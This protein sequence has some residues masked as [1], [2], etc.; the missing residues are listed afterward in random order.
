MQNLA[1]LL[2]LACV[3]GRLFVGEMPMLSP[4]LSMG[5]MS[6]AIQPTINLNEPMRVSFAIVLL[7]ATAGWLL[8]GAMTGELRTRRRG[9]A[10]LMGVFV[11]LSLV[12]SLQAA[13]KR[14]AMVIWVEQFSLMAACWLAAQVFADRRHMGLLLAFAAGAGAVLCLKGF[15]QVFDEIPAMQAAREELFGRPLTV[16]D[17]LHAARAAAAKPAGFFPL[18]NAFGSVLILL[19]AALAAVTVS[20]LHAGAAAMRDVSAVR[21]QIPLPLLQ[22]VCA[23]AV[24]VGCG[25]VLMMTG[26]AGAVIAAAVAAVCAGLLAV[27]AS[28]L[29]RHWRKTVVIS[30]VLVLLAGGGVVAFGTA[31]GRL[32]GKTMTVRWHYW[33]GSAAI[34]AER[35]L[36]GVG[37]GNF[38]DAYLR[39]RS[40]EAEEAVQTPHNFLVHAVAQFGLP[41]GLLYLG[42]IAI[43]L[44]AA[45]RPRSH[46]L[47]TPKTPALSLRTALPVMG[48]AL[49]L[50]RT[51]DGGPWESQ[52]RIVFDVV[53]PTVAFAL[54]VLLFGSRPV[55]ATST[56]VVRVAIGCGLAG[57]LLHN[58]VS[59]GLSMPGPATLFWVL[60]G[61]AMGLA[62]QRQPARARRGR[63]PIAAIMLAIVVA[64]G[65]FVARPTWAK[66]HAV[67]R[68]R[69]A[70]LAGPSTIAY[71]LLTEA[72]QVDRQDATVAA[73]KARLY[74]HL[75][76]RRRVFQINHAASAVQA[77]WQ[78]IGRCP[79]RSSYRRLGAK[80]W[81]M[82]A[83]LADPAEQT[84]ARDRATK[85][86]VQSVQRDPMNV[87]L[88]IECA[89]AMLEYG[90]KAQ[91]AEHLDAAKQIDERRSA[92]SLFR[93][94]AD[95]RAILDDLRRRA[96]EN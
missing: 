92:D 41:G 42:V 64:A 73:E 76:E 60:L 77:T 2:L 12:S 31:K 83:A 48:L 96:Q 51:I 85:R 10:A 5:A 1:A 61:A 39:H 46:P 43:G 80:A 52:A 62:D 26:S 16:F 88:R 87:R 63:W 54:A 27:F 25:V 47:E 58:M 13:D 72:V 8:G 29:R 7:A 78:A 82:Y 55:S 20:R 95:E 30:W 49:L 84:D 79:T 68:A 89:A 81:G 91:A 34:V 36:L 19:M 86:W 15:N 32:P 18:S 70:F 65:W 94:T 21:G 37:G 71:N 59:V 6:K 44:T 23:A 50:L 35:P 93:L 57:F 67:R 22:G 3:A 28:R 75:A 45:S 11:A 53:L 56:A 17:R 66:T 24:L 4:V 69:A 38:P 74:L 33:T 14:A 90:R 9:L 40:A